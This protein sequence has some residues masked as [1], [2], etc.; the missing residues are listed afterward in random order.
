MDPSKRFLTLVLAAGVIVLVAAIVVGERAGGRVFVAAQKEGSLETSP[1]VTPLPQSTAD[2]NGYGPDWKRSQTL[3]A[4]VDPGF[5]DPRVP[6]VAPPTPAPEPKRTSTP[7][8]DWTPNPKLPI[9][10]Q[11]PPPTPSAS[12]EESATPAGSAQP[13]VSPS[14]S[15][16]TKISATPQP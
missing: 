10:D 16:G 14:P 4:A 15:P 8:P 2:S 1:I 5:P 6:P 9:W 11:T 12:P 3:A 7:R 13:S